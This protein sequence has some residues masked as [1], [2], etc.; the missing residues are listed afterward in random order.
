M[1]SLPASPVIG[2]SGFGPTTGSPSVVEA[3]CI[4]MDCHNNEMRDWSGFEDSDGEH[5]SIGRLNGL[6]KYQRS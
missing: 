1:L 5:I 6:S 3:V 4:S 2:F